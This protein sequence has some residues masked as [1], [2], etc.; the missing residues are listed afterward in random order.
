MT[1]SASSTSAEPQCEL[2]ARFP[3]LATS[4]PAP[5]TTIALTVEMLNVP[6]RSPPV[7]TTSTAGAGAC[8]GFA[9]PSMVRARP[10]TSSAVSPF[11]SQCHQ[12]AA[13]LPGGGLASHDPA[14]RLSGLVGVEVLVPY[15]PREDVGPEVRIDVGLARL[16]R[17]GDRR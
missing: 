13:N 15:E 5:A 17:H 9:N 11:V 2:A 6:L 10:S 8:T 16:F 12:E 4:T 14:H 3:C 7:P 1:P